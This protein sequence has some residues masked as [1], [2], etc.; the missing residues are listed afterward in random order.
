M[1][2]KPMNSKERV[3]AVFS[4]YTPDRVPWGEFAIDFDTAAK[5]I[6]HETYYRAK[7]KS[8]MAFW[9]G[10]RD[11]VVQS[12]KEDSIELF[13]KLDC[14]DIINVSAL[15]C[16]IAPPEGYKP[17][18]PKKINEN[19]WEYRNGTVIKYSEIT[20][21][22]TVVYDPNVGTKQFIP[23][24]FDKK[25]DVESIDQSC[26]EV[27]DTIIKEFG[28]DRFITGPSGHEV[29]ILLLEGD[30]EKGGGGFVQG[31]MHYYDNP[32]LVK[33]AYRHEVEKNNKLDYQY[34]RTGQ[35][36]VLLAQQ[37]FAT[38]KGPFI[39]PVMFREFALPS[40]KER[41]KHIHDNFEMPVIKHCC[42]N[43]N[44]LLEMFIEIKYDAYQS[45]QSTAGMEISKIKELYGDCLIPWGGI[46]VEDLVS[47]TPED[48]KKTVAHSMEHYKPGGRYIFGSSHSIA[49]GTKYE[50]FMAMLDEFEKLRYY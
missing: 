14:L 25:P 11:E 46:D 24:D 19:T 39:S 33:A 5:V 8:E 34:I 45:I 13:R 43:T 2:R 32:E 40:I 48:I 20:S 27:V 38:T 28:S 4:G 31:L 26:F 15:A 30:F 10:R 7:A 42:G 21:D 37:D 35:D 18:K 17:E 6:G 49:V 29:G 16:G 1:G 36:A 12:W 23:T 50:N 22:L 3:K 41:V 47:G 9:D 44:E